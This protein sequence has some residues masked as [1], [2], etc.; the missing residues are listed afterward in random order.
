MHSLGARD[1]WRSLLRRAAMRKNTWFISVCMVVLILLS[2]PVLAQV[3]F[4]LPPPN[5]CW[6]YPA[7]VADFNGDGKPDLV[8]GSG[9]VYLGK[10]DGTF[11]SGAAIAGTPLAVA[12]FNGDGKADVLEQS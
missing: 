1:R 6:S 2:F 11:T 7:F 10:G 3:S 5:P 9:R 4:L 8:C 12:D